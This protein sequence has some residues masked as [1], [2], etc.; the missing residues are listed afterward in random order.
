MLDT[1][2]MLNAVPPRFQKLK[3]E[4]L[5]FAMARGNKGA[6]AMEMTK[7]F[8]TNYHYIVPELSL[9]DEYR[10]NATKIIN[11]Y[12]EAKAL[13]VQTKINIIGPI[14]YLG[15]SKR[16]DGGDTYALLENILKVYEALLIE[17]ATLDDGI[18][19][20]IDEP[21]FAKDNETKVL[22]LIK[23]TYDRL[24]QV[25][26]KINIVVTTYFEHSNKSDKKLI[27]GVVDGRNIWKNDMQKTLQL[28]NKIA[29]SVDKEQIIIASSCSLL[30]TPFSLEYET[31]MSAEIKNW[32]AYSK[33]K[34][35]EITLISK[36]FF[37][38][39]LTTDENIQFQENIQANQKYTKKRKNRKI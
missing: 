3:D 33:E 31:Q 18:T 34:L 30:H 38:E 4:I 10:L 7:W 29:L 25:N 20:Q 36:L 9:E 35:N 19:L 8:N 15:L 2:I 1:S 27:A 28:L 21:I 6:V 13:G 12:N 17:I 26:N 23:P 14:T 11:E 16:S 39:I 32:L 24:A 22:S 5:Y 37:K